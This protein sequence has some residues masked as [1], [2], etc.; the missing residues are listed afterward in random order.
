VFK[1]S[2]VCT[3]FL[4]LTGAVLQAQTLEA[5]EHD[6]VIQGGAMAI[7]APDN[8]TFAFIGAEAGLPGKSVKGSPYSADA[9]TESVQTLADGN[10][11]TTKSTATM[12]R[13]SEGRTRREQ[14]LPMIGPFSSD[15]P[16]HKMITINDPVAGV[17]WILNDTEKT[18]RKLPRAEMV[19]TAKSSSGVAVQKE[20]HVAMATGA[21]PVRSE[22][23]MIRHIGSADAKSLPTPK[24]ETLGQR[25]FDD[26][27]A[28]GT[29]S[30]ITIPA[31]TVG[32]ER[33]I[34]VVDERWVSA[35]LQTV[36]MSKH[37]DPRMGETTYRLTNISRNEPSPALFQVPVDYKVVEGDQPMELRIDKKVEK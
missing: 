11:I 31:G 30:T 27:V 1:Q 10:K 16:A 33:P 37:T 2:V 25:T 26:V 3:A 15:G 28:D 9:V 13:D 24:S 34:E 23:V 4:A 22:Q 8:A 14:S 32:N 7:P 6:I 19:W 36:V 35:D 21:G 12:A 17:T 18:A 5:P 20:V 29:R